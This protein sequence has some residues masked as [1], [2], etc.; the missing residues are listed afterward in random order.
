MT[1]NKNSIKYCKYFIEF[2][3]HIENY[4]VKLQL[5][6]NVFYKLDN[7]P[8]LSDDQSALRLPLLYVGDKS[9]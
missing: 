9:R 4:G 5:I 2:L 3:L 1:N 7:L 6:I 8:S